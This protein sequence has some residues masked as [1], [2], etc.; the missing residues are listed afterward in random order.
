MRYTLAATG[1]LAAIILTQTTAYAIAAP[2]QDVARVFGS[3]MLSAMQQSDDGTVI[4]KKSSGEQM[5]PTTDFSTVQGFGTVREVFVWNPS[6]VL[7][8]QLERPTNPINEWIAPALEQ[9]GTP[10]GTA[11]AWR[12]KGKKVAEVGGFNNDKELAVA[13]VSLSPSAQLVQDNWRLVFASRR[14]R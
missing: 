5:Q 1:A 3:P 8:A 9:D 12:P 2:P 4:A 13:L 11:T 14:L 10:I 6:F 7:N